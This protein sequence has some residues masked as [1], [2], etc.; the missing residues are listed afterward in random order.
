MKP[1][2]SAAQTHHTDRILRSSASNRP[3]DD[4]DQGLAAEKMLPKCVFENGPTSSW[5][6][7]TRPPTA[8]NDALR[9]R[10]LQS[11][12]RESGTRLSFVSLPRRARPLGGRL[13]PGHNGDRNP[14][15]ATKRLLAR[16]RE[17]RRKKE[18]EPPSTPRPP[19]RSAIPNRRPTRAAHDNGASRRTSAGARPRASWCSWCPSWFNL[20][21]SFRCASSRL[22]VKL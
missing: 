18:I 1:Q 14:I 22:R 10:V 3:K 16:S 12:G 8:R 4:L 19:R 17:G 11:G 2:K 7:A 6:A 20:S 13:P 9:A 5:P 15:P 21:S